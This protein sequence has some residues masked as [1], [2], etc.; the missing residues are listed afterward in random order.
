VIAG[1]VNASLEPMIALR[2][3]SPKGI[4]IDID[5]VVDTVFSGF[6]T[7]PAPAVTTLGM[8]RYSVSRAMLADGTVRHFDLYQAE[9]HWDNS[10]RRVLVTGLGTEVLAGMQLLEGHELRVVARVNGPVTISPLP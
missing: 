1:V 5:A 2:I 8:S 10:W 7:L 4:E 9:V 6:L 3:K